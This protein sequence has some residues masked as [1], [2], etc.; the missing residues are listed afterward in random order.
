MTDHFKNIQQE[1]GDLTDDHFAISNLVKT[2]YDECRTKIMEYKIDTDTIRKII[3]K[4]KRRTAPGHDGITTEHLLHANSEALCNILSNIYTIML[5]HN[6]V[7][8][9][10]Q[11]G[12]I[13]PILKK[14]TLTQTDY[15]NYR[16]ITLCSVHAKIIEL[17][18]LPDFTPTD[19]Q[20]G[21]QTGKGVEFCHGMLND[22]AHI[23]NSGESPLYICTLDAVKCFDSIWHDGL[24]FKLIDILSLME[25]RYLYNWYKSLKAIVRVNGTESKPFKVEKGTRQ[26]SIIS[27]HLFNIYIDDLLHELKQSPYGIQIMNN[28]YNSIAYADDITLLSLTITDMQMLIDICF[29]YSQK[30]RFTYGIKKSECLTIGD[31][32][33]VKDPVLYLGKEKIKNVNSIEI[34]GYTYNSSGTSIGHIAN[35]IQKSRKA[36]RAIGLQNELLCPMLKSQLWKSIGVPSLAYSLG[37]NAITT[38]ELKL[39]ESTQGTTIKNSLYLN[40]RHRHSKLLEAMGIPSIGDIVEKQRTSLL[41][42]VF[43]TNSTYT[44]LCM[45]LMAQVMHNGRTAKGTLL[46]NIIESGRSPLAIMLGLDSPVIPTQPQP[47]G[48]RESISNVLQNV[49]LPGSHHHTLLKGLTNAF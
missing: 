36:M 25:W 21:Y 20:Y 44:T 14:P 28:V 18:I 49:I 16:P 10:L 9:N 34:L 26:G 45:S 48:V 8:T 1:S 42:R 33:L 11:I 31:K 30:W 12:V 6:V 43:L 4:L 29:T 23:A 5:T 19:S 47:D 13:I 40:K 39:L 24:F 41:H 46:Q 37:T 22:I 17:L 2:K 3:E 38:S 32:N 15:N 35:R 7:P 27:P